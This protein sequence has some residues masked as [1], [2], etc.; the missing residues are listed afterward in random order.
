MFH[1]RPS[2]TDALDSPGSLSSAA[3]SLSP[4]GRSPAPSRRCFVLLGLAPDIS[5]SSAQTVQ[6]ALSARLG[7]LPCSDTEL[8]GFFNNA[9]QQ[10]AAAKQAGSADEPTVEVPATAAETQLWQLFL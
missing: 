5:E 3:L 7:S 9:F 10:T 2:S 6:P 8:L 1:A 4:C